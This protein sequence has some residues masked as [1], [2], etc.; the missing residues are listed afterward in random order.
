[1]R[2]LTIV[3]VLL[4]SFPALA[5]P[6]ALTSADPD[7]AGPLPAAER[8]EGRLVI[9]FQGSP[10]VAEL[11]LWGALYGLRPVP[12]SPH[13]L[14]HGLTVVEVEEGRMADLLSRL[15]ADPIVECVSP[16]YVVHSAATPTDSG[17]G[18]EWDT[19]P[20]KSF[21]NDPLFKYQWHLNMVGAKKAWKQASG[22]GVTIALLDTGVAY[23]TQGRVEAAEDLAQTE[24]VKGYDFVNQDPDAVDDNGIGT[25]L[26]GTL[27][28]STHN[29]LGVAGLAYKAK[30]MPL[31]VL[32]QRGSGTFSA[33]A[34]AVRFAADNGADILTMGFGSSADHEL[35]YNS[36]M[37][38]RQKGCLLVAAG[39]VNGGS[40][41]GYPADY[42]EVLGVGSVGRD[43][44]VTRYSNGGVDMVAPGGYGSEG[45]GIF[46]NT[47]H[48]NRPSRQGYLWHAGSNCAAAHVVGAAALVMSKGVKDPDRV[49]E[50]LLSTADKKKDK[51]SYGAGILRA[52]KAIGKASQTTE[53]VGISW[54]LSLLLLGWLGWRARRG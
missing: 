29:D 10:T 43:G 22:E 32:D 39:G 41:P 54:V 53:G 12:T 15:A 36:L 33:I 51:K 30:I 46:Q 34:D 18:P 11:A 23:K 27:A 28:Q 9:D 4:L 21:P 49:R 19:E 14:K 45:Q 48:R 38:A 1:M 5:Q 37:Y 20:A 44:R 17:E 8:L 31:K 35:L 26:A 7:G 16:D 13:G 47:F 6:H 2:S 42:E 24:F 3:L 50:I 40:H 25:H 52:D